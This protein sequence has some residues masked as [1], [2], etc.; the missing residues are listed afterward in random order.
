MLKKQPIFSQFKIEDKD[1]NNF[2]KQVKELI[3]ELPSPKGRGLLG[4]TTI[5]LSSP[6][7]KA[8]LSKVIPR[9]KAMGFRMKDHKNFIFSKET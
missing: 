2:F 7:T 5:A 8:G 6:S 4:S 9:L 1:L 3:C